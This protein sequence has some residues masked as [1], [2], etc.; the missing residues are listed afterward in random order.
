MAYACLRT[1]RHAGRRPFSRRSTDDFTAEPHLSGFRLDPSDLPKVVR[2]CDADHIVDFDSNGTMFFVSPR[3]RDLIER[4]EFG[5][6]QFELVAFVDPGGRSSSL[7]ANPLIQVTDHEQACCQRCR[8]A[9]P[10]RV[11]APRLWQDREPMS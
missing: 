3:A 8:R 11:T 4:L 9:L 7:C 5:M 2:I 10:Q 6:H 1:D